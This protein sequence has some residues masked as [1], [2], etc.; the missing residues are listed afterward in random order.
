MNRDILPRLSSG[1]MMR[2]LVELDRIGVK[3]SGTV[4]ELRTRDY[5]YSELKKA[6]IDTYI[7][8]FTYLKYSSPKTKVSIISPIQIELNCNPV[9]Y[10]ASTIG[11]AL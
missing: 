9:S 2:H 3:W 8:E 1:E 6:G 5:L 7:D 10:V 4:G 11:S